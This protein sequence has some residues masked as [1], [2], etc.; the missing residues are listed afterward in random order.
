MSGYSI[1]NKNK[2]GKVEIN[3][4]V[5]IE[6]DNNFIKDLIVTNSLEKKETKNLTASI[7]KKPTIIN[8][9][10]KSI[11]DYFE[12]NEIANEKNKITPINLIKHSKKYLTQSFLKGN[13]PEG[14]PKKNWAAVLGFILSFFIPFV[15]IWF[16]LIGLKSEQRKLALVGYIISITFILLYVIVT[17]A[18]L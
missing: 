1:A 18:T 14:N 7:E 11:K 4:L 8:K 15:A 9:T 12:R 17:L 16:C 13:K 10:N 5:N 2:K 3:G 6:V